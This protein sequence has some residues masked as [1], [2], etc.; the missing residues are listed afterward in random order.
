[1]SQP[2]IEDRPDLNT[3][4]PWSEMDLF[5]L[6]NCVRLRQ[7]VE[8]IAGFMCRSRREVRDK[9]AELKQAGELERRVR[10]TAANARPE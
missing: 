2:D 1:M 8:E 7:P 10:E 4:K 6:A 9:I 3:G 5:D